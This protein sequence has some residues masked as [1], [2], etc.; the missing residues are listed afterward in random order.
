MAL[1]GDVAVVGAP[2]A[3]APEIQSGAAY[4]FRRDSTTATWSLEATFVASDGDYNDLF[5]YSVAI[6]RDV[7]VIGAR[8]DENDGAHAAGS[9]YVFRFAESTWLEE[10]KLVDPNGESGDLLGRAVAIEGDVILLGAPGTDHP[11]G[12][13]GSV[14]VFR[15]DGNDWTLE[16]ELLPFDAVGKQRFGLS[17]SLAMSTAAVG[18]THDSM[19]AGAAYIFHW[20]GRQW[21]SEATLVPSDPV[22]SP[23]FGASVALSADTNVLLVGAVR[24]STEG[25]EAGAAY[26][27]RREN[28]VWTQ[29]TKLTASDAGPGDLF[30]A[31][32]SIDGDVGIVGAPM[33]NSSPGAGY[34]FAG[35]AGVDC[36]GNGEPDAC[37]IFSGSAEDSNGN[38]IP[39]ECESVGDL[40]GDG[41][42]NIVDFLTLLLVWGPCGAPCPPGCVGDT[43]GNCAVDASDLLT[44]FDNWG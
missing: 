43:D 38:G 8:N 10:E 39:D 3:W 17:V 2:D 4:V 31:S 44:M 26:L 14:F 28:N 7:I 42:V 32:V 19:Q 30:G 35:L 9:A 18:A 27:F 20:N 16:A 15:N 29:I 40:N 11:D 24:D 6:D 34:V 22:G 37:D 41:T 33:Q 5:G 36:D 25:F 12:T 23:F 13:N 21:I 1:S